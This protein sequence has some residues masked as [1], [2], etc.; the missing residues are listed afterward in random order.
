M[1]DEADEVTRLRRRVNRLEDQIEHVYEPKLDEQRSLIAGLSTQVDDL[2]ETVELLAERVD[3]IVDAD[4]RGDSSPEARA[5]A[6]REAMIRAAG[7]TTSLSG[8]VTWWWKEVRD[9]LASHGHGDFSKPVYHTAIEDAAEKDGFAE[10]T[11][12]VISGNQRREVKAIQ[13]DPEA[14][15]SPRLRNQLTTRESGAGVA[16]PTSTSGEAANTSD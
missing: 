16:D 6:L 13:L 1:S 9:Q 4:G 5:V 14:V 10:T 3:G 8:G 11:K 2:E 15:T 12:E 7:D